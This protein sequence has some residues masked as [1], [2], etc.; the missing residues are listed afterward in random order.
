[1]P[2]LAPTRRRPL[3]FRAPIFTN[4][5]VPRV[6][7]CKPYMCFC[8]PTHASKAL[9]SC[10]SSIPLPAARNSEKFHEPTPATRATSGCSTPHVDHD[11]AP[12]PA[13]Q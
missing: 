13:S 9:P 5:S 10:D 12:H 4:T 2:S 8:R 1:V 7:H 6:F 3:F 11:T